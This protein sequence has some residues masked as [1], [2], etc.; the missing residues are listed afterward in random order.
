M[1]G[2]SRPEAGPRV[3]L[4]WAENLLPE[5]TAREEGAER[6]VFTCNKC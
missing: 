1:R 3:P 6:K 5:V 4:H 2:V